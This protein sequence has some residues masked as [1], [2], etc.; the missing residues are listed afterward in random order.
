MASGRMRS[1][2]VVTVKGVFGPAVRARFADVEVSA[3][4]EVTEL[5][6]PDA[7]QASLFGL[8][9][10]IEDLGLEVLEVRRD[11]SGQATP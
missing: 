4:D 7:D 1:D 6:E 11:P 8:L 2:Y 9:R 5:R 3:L 10:R